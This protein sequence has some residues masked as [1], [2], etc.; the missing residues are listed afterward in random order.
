LGGTISTE[1]PA[2]IVLFD[3][4]IL[5]VYDGYIGG[6]SNNY[7]IGL[8]GSG[9]VTIY[10]GEVVAGGKYDGIVTEKTYK[11][12]LEIKG[13]EIVGNNNAIYAQCPGSVVIDSGRLEGL[14]YNAIAGGKQCNITVNNGELIGKYS[15]IRCTSDCKVEINGGTITASDN[16]GVEMGAGS[17]LT[18]FGGTIS[19]TTNGIGVYGGSTVTIGDATK[20]V[21]NASITCIG[22]KYGLNLASGTVNYNSGTLKGK[23]A[24]YNGSITVRSGYTATTTT[25]GDYK[26]T[27]LTK[28]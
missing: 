18:V 15:G 1:G 12:T 14:T 13:G 11:G 19:G 9:N 21:D 5:E 25:S 4:S 17:T 8:D 24:G 2:A 26:V 20:T 27:T 22:E 28:K 23:T 3:N 7:G 10:G 6:A 16:D